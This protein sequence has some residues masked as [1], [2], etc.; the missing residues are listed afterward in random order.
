[1][2][3]L[4][5]CKIGASLLLRSKGQQLQPHKHSDPIRTRFEQRW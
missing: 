1:M 5:R 4:Y 3:W 2:D